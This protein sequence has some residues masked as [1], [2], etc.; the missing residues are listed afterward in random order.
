MLLGFPVGGVAA[1][2]HSS[3]TGRHVA[4]G[5]LLAL[6]CM[7]ACAASQVVTQSLRYWGTLHGMRRMG[8]R[9][10]REPLPSDSFGL[11]KPRDFWVAAAVAAAGA[12][13]LLYAAIRAR[14]F[15]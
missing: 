7:V 6:G 1:V 14:G 12:G 2:L 9:A 8:G 3:R 5:V 10:V 11:P 15:G 4:A 13:V